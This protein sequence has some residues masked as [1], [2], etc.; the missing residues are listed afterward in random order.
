MTERRYI[1]IADARLRAISFVR[2]FAEA[3][4]TGNPLDSPVLRQIALESAVEDLI[5]E[6]A[7]H[8]TNDEDDEAY[9]A[10]PEDFEPDAIVL[11]LKKPGR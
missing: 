10:E 1:Y 7:T 6:I 5:E 9:D 3:Q 11:P 4:S 2:D 8:W